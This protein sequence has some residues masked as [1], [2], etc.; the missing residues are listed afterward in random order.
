MPDALLLANENQNAGCQCKDGHDN[1]KTETHQSHQAADDQIDCEQEHSEVFGDVHVSLSE[2]KPARLH[3][4][5]C[6]PLDITVSSMEPKSRHSFHA[7]ISCPLERWW[8][9]R[10]VISRDR[11]P[12]NSTD[13]GVR[14]LSLSLTR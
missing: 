9:V 1:A 8:P 13:K 12:R 5:N 3:A 6:V 2:A 10:R 14:D 4:L 11:S 7:E